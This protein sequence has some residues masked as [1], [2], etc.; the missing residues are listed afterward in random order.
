MFN[1]PNH[2]IVNNMSNAFAD[3]R[4]VISRF[5]FALHEA[6]CSAR[7]LQLEPGLHTI[8]TDN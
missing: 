8:S 3:H 5:L 2:G 4:R 1:E 7:N 6:L